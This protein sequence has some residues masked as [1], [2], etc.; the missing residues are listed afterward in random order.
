MN[1]RA[2]AGVSAV[3]A[4]VA[5]TL[6]SCAE[7]VDLRDTAPD[8]GADSGAVSDADA[9]Q[10]VT[11]FDPDRPL[12]ADATLAD[13][14]PMLLTS[15]RG[16]DQRVIDG[17]ATDTLARL[18][19]TWAAA[20]PLVR[21]DHPSSLFGL[22]QAIDLARSAVERRRPADASKGY[23]LAIELTDEILTR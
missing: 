10:V 13:L 11:T 20:A 2:T 19:A 12:P 3:V 7:T 8:S 9:G 16:L 23:R 21:A 6:S 22:E 15:W 14:F 4:V 5:L 18:E 17:D 1:R